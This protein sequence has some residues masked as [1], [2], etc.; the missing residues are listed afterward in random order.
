MHP[1]DPGPKLLYLAR[2]AIAARLGL[3]PPP[4]ELAAKVREPGACFITLTRQ[5]EL[6]GCIGS[7]EAY[8]S[9][10]EDVI[11]NACA[12]AFQD[13]RFPPVS[14]AEWP[15]I[16]LE[17]S[18]LTT[19]KPLSCRDEADLLAQLKP[20]E[21]GLILAEGARRATFLPQVW[22]QLPD[23]VDF[24][25]RLRQKAG[26]PTHYWSP[27]LQFWRYQVQKWKETP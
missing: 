2:Q 3:V 27:R 8:R 13:P 17:V 18:L 9:L 15:E 23:P 1:T 20:G 12:A 14:A 25:D 24:L 26:L 22:E 11:H 5:G 19:P 6:R 10:G 7:L 4:T 16:H 21:D